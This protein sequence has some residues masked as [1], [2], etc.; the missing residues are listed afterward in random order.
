[1]MDD[2]IRKCPVCASDEQGA[3]LCNH[4][5]LV[6][7]YCEYFDYPQFYDIDESCEEDRQEYEDFVKSH[8]SGILRWTE[9]NIRD[10]HTAEVYFD[11]PRRYAF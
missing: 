9:Q 10:K 8:I 7:R 11:N 4:L 6:L 1:M 3:Q 5:L 2:I